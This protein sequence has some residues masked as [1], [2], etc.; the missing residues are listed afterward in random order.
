MIQHKPSLPG[1]A[2]HAAQQRAS[3]DSIET[4]VAD[5]RVHELEEMVLALQEEIEETRQNQAGAQNGALMRTMVTTSSELNEHGD[6]LQENEDH[7]SVAI[8]TTVV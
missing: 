4:V 8:S 5:Q 3:I 6:Q 2:L 7:A 1:W